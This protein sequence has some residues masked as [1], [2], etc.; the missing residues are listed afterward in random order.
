MLW[1]DPNYEVGPPDQPVPQDI[2]DGRSA[3]WSEASEG[4]IAAVQQDLRGQA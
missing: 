2:W 4:F 3:E 1:Y